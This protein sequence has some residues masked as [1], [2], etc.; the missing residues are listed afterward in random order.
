[1][2][3]MGYLDVYPT[4]MQMAGLKIDNPDRLDG[5][6]CFDAIRNDI[7]TP[8]KA[9]YY[10]YRDADMIRTP[11]WKLFR[12]HDGSVELYDLQNDIGENDN[13]AKAHP[14]LVASLRQQLQTWMRDHAIATSHMPLS[15]SAASPSGEVLEVSFSLQKEATPRAPQRIIF[16]QPAG[17]CTTRTYFQYDI[18]VD[19]SSVQAG[20]H[21]GPVYR[22]TSLFQ[23]RGIIDDRGTPVSPN[24]RPV[25]KP[26]QWECRRIGMATF[27]PHKIAPIAIHITRAQKGSTFKF[28][29]DNI[30]I[31]QLGSNTRKD[32]WQQGKVRARPTSGITGL[33]IRPVSYS[34]VK[35]P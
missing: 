30:R 5:R 15:P 22:K 14:E 11:R 24:Y 23:R 25:N 33:Q 2:G 19:A 17:T 10:L 21:I 6:P 8:V 26:N 9:Y 29:L 1:S 20:F 35:K 32:I 28:Y 4:C 13:V 31:A 16:S 34:L 7:P 18:C 3:L 27:C 12:R